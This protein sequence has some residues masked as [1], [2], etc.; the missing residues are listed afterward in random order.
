MSKK[1]NLSRRSRQGAPAVDRE[2]Q[3]DRQVRAWLDRCIY[4]IYAFAV[5]VVS[6]TMFEFANGPRS[7]FSAAVA[8]GLSMLL[9]WLSVY[10]RAIQSVEFKERIRTLLAKSRS[11]GALGNYLGFKFDSYF[12]LSLSGL[13]RQTRNERRLAR[14]KI[15][16]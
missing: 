15:G 9:A 2:L 6:V 13:Y 5:V 10:L 1:K 7:I 4:A 16:S 8:A 3:R 11:V 14:K 12:F